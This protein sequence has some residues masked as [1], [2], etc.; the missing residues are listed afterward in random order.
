MPVSDDVF[1]LRPEEFESLCADL[2]RADGYKNVAEVGGAHDQGVDITAN[3]NGQLV[4]VQVKHTKRLLGDGEI[5][6]IVERI[7]QNDYEVDQ[8]ILMTS[9]Q[10]S[11]KIKTGVRSRVPVKILDLDDI[12]GLLEKHSTIKQQKLKR[13]RKRQA[14]QVLFIAL[15]LFGVFA[16]LFGLLSDIST[17]LPLKDHPG[18]DSRIERVDS[19]LK[20]MKGLESHLS[21]IKTDMKKTAEESK[22]I[23][24]EYQKALE[25]KTL[26]ADQLAMMRKALE[27]ES[28]Q[29]RLLN[30]I[31]GFLLGIA[32]SIT[33]SIIYSRIRQHRA[34][35]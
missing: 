4:A 9:S 6:R 23:E 26:T 22:K 5:L 13:A 19:A 32:S 12:V 25:L 24:E 1:K 7:M 21:Q 28:W 18:L 33:A 8:I 10:I 34:L 27:S 30:Y 11:G 15:S 2:L 14:H 16:S 29:Q 3:K 35:N 20:A 31:L 17:L